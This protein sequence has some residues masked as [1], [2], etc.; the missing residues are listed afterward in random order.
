[1]GV[2]SGR[3]CEIG[4]KSKLVFHRMVFGSAASIRRLKYFIHVCLFVLIFQ[5][6]SLV[7]VLNSCGSI[8]SFP[9][10]LLSLHGS[11]C[12]HLQRAIVF[13]LILFFFLCQI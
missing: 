6:T 3:N 8:G 1:M 11:S 2:C 12:V 4:L 7:A 5:C 9:T 13:L 10:Q